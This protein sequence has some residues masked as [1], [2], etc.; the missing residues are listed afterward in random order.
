MASVAAAAESKE[1]FGRPPVRSSVSSGTWMPVATVESKSFVVALIICRSALKF[2]RSLAFQLPFQEMSCVSDLRRA[3]RVSRPKF[4]P[5]SA[6][7][8]SVPFSN[9]PCELKVAPGSTV[10]LYGVDACVKIAFS[11]HSWL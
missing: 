3:T 11:S 2:Q 4:R 9:T 5:P 10:R 1:I 7:S 6:S 8:R